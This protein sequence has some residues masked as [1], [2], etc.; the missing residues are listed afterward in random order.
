MLIMALFI[1][2]DQQDEDNK[3]ACSSNS[4]CN[5]E[6]LPSISIWYPTCAGQILQTP[7]G[8]GEAICQEDGSCGIDFTLDERD[9]TAEGLT[10]GANTEPNVQGDTCLPSM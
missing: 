8:T 6:D 1:N 9:C 2:C 10:C 3:F 5:Q 7:T 4:D